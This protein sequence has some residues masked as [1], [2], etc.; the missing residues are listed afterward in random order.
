MTL[1]M[2]AAWY[3]VFAWKRHIFVWC[4]ATIA[5]TNF[6]CDTMVFGASAQNQDRKVIRAQVHGTFAQKLH[7]SKVQ[8]VWHS[9]KTAQS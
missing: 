3:S 9:T 8:C 4:T 7:N 6:A 1:E 2:V 5:D